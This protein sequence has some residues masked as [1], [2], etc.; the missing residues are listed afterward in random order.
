MS[1]ESGLRDHVVIVTGGGSGI[2]KEVA[3]QFAEKGAS[4][5]IVGRTAEPLV[6]RL[7]L[8]PGARRR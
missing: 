2:G 8:E 1:P 7:Q 6:E 5:M 3:R 4:V